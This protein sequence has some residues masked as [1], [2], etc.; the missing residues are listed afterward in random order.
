MQEETP[1]NI[2]N[3]LLTLHKTIYFSLET[4]LTT[5]SQYS[6]EAFTRIET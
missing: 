1:I 5:C 4:N 3:K 6:L 2:K